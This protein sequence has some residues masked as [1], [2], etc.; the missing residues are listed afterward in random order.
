MVAAGVSAADKGSG[1]VTISESVK[2]GASQLAPG[3]YKL[4]WEGTGPNVQVTFSRGKN[5]FTTPATITDQSNPYG[6]TAVIVK[7]DN[8]SR[9][10][11]SIQL[12]K[13]LLVFEGEQTQAGR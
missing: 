10:L 3:D 1:N 13:H 8:G 6:R 9:V 4:S 11:N 5:S 7:Q 2:I 12:S